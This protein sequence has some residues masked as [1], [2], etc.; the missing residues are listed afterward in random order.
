MPEDAGSRCCDG[1]GCC[2]EGFCCEGWLLGCGVVAFRSPLVDSGFDSDLLLELL[3]G[4]L[5]GVLFGS[6][7]LASGGLGWLLRSCSAARSRERARSSVALC[8][9]GFGLEGWSGSL[10]EGVP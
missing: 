9:A 10:G 8:S 5:S 2:C 1:E 6:G 3:L 7:F 4:L